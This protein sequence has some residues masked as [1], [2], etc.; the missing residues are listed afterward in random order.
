MSAVH[1]R[2]ERVVYGVENKVSGALGS[3]F[4]IHTHPNL[5][6]HF[7]VLSGLLRPLLSPFFSPLS[8]PYYNNNNININN[9]K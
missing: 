3:L 8:L 2:F 6:H 9:N 1:A 5:N 7:V 4:A